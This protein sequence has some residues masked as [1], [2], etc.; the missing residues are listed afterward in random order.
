MRGSLCTH[1]CSLAAIAASSCGLGPPPP[2]FFFFFLA[3]P[4]WDSGFFGAAA[5][6][7]RSPELGM[8]MRAANIDI[9]LVIEYQ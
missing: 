2:P 3:A 7:L 1:S 8:S 6:L 9:G 5:P 4:L